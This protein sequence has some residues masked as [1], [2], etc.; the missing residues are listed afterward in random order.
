M[1][2]AQIV[3]LDID[4]ANSDPNG[5]AEDQQP[6]VGTPFVLNGAQ[7][8]L[9][10]AGQWD[11]GDA[12]ADIGGAQISFES[13]GNWSGVTFTITGK[14]PDG[15]SLVV[16]Q[17]G[18]NATTV[19]TTAY[20]SQIT[21][22]TADGTVATDIEVGAADALIS[23]TVPLNGYS[24]YRATIA[25]VALSGTIQFDI[26][27]TFDDVLRTKTYNATTGAAV[28]N[29]VDIVSNQTTA[30]N[31]QATLYA[32]AIRLVIDSYTDT[33]EFQF[34]IMQNPWD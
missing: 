26:Q 16:T 8:D 4:P 23:R 12:Y 32:Q 28:P 7:S 15:E 30:Q 17:A 3:K 20:F 1:S 18:P 2:S 5:I 6:D 11:I 10:T 19:T 31:N 21:S 14:D 29:W 22:I 33:A 25:V 34:H 24:D 27:E 9:G 13:A